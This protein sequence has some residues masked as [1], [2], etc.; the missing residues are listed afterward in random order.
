[1]TILSPPGFGSCC[2]FVTVLP[3]MLKNFRNEQHGAVTGLM[4]S[5]F[6]V[7]PAAYAAVYGG[8]FVDGYVFQAAKQNLSGFYLFSAITCLVLYL[9]GIVFI[10]E[11]PKGEENL[12][13]MSIQEE[14]AEK[15][16]RED[17]SMTPT[18][19][20]DTH[21]IAA[22]DSKKISPSRA[23]D[24]EKTNDSFKE[25]SI[26]KAA[27]DL[28]DAP[29]LTGCELFRK[30]EFQLLLWPTIF[31]STVQL[32]FMNNMSAILKSF[33]NASFITLASVLSPV[34][35][36]VSTLV[37]GL[38]TDY[39]VKKVP[40]VTYAIVVNVLQFLFLTLAI[41]YAGNVT[42]FILT[43]ISNSVSAG[44]TMT[45][46]PTIL[47]EISGTQYFGRNLGGMIIGQGGGVF[48]LQIIIGVIYDANKGDAEDRNCYGD[49]CFRATFI[50]LSVLAFVTLALQLCHLN[51][52]LRRRRKTNEDK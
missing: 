31:I 4:F 28:P 16:F 12:A 49:R 18:P 32:T 52:I 8:C 19:G 29:Q 45:I 9:L 17:L 10:R 33:N 13:D 47:A 3:V 39:T 1:M 5:F 36:V 7:G 26:T 25:S 42:L 34:V 6:S 14:L 22:K 48:V 23:K 43:V 27:E 35:T 21:L 37:I 44:G 20:E 41:F 38:V 11:I 51:L 15:S 50:I 2:G 40:R 30:L 24:P 46:S